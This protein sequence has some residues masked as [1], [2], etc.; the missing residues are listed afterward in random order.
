MVTVNVEKYFYT[1]CL[2]SD[3]VSCMQVRDGYGFVV[4]DTRV[5]GP[6]LSPRVPRLPTLLGRREDRRVCVL[7][8]SVSRRRI[9][10]EGRSFGNRVDK[11]SGGDSQVLVKK[12]IVYGRS[13]DGLRSVTKLLTLRNPG[14]KHLEGNIGLFR[15]MLDKLFTR[16]LIR[17]TRDVSFNGSPPCLWDFVLPLRRSPFY[18]APLRG[19]S[20]CLTVLLKPVT[21]WP[22]FLFLWHSF[23]LDVRVYRDGLFP[24]SNTLLDPHSIVQV[25]PG[26]FLTCILN[27]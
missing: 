11:N 1:G 12:W 16:S 18:E 4:V 22:F 6:F 8:G 10:M 2:N 25:S 15:S 26:P 13:V 14:T 23:L 20:P 3:L 9:G 17:M 24:E 19:P 7:E 5:W 27:A 21:S